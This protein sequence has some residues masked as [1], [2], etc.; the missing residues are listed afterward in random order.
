MNWDEIGA[1]G[2]VLGSIAV[3]VTL[4]YLSIQVRHARDEVERSIS[5]NRLDSV[6][7]VLT[8]RINN[9]G[10]QSIRMKAIAALGGRYGPFE[11]ALMERAGLIPEEAVAL[12]MD[13]HVF[14]L[15]Q[16]EAIPFSH[17]LRDGERIAFDFG[18]RGAY[19]S[20]PLGALWFASQKAR[21][22]PDAVRYVDNL[23]AQPV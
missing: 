8:N 17:R 6:R 7:Q 15:C 20:S 13:M 18:L 12:G 22:D 16:A 19:A 5:H 21:L 3:F 9:E 4:A 1:I 11:A 10:L 14:W 2:Q 23:L